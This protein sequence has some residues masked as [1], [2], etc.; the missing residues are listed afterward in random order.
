MG[1][2]KD[3][4]PQLPY[5]KQKLHSVS[6]VMQPQSMLIPS[7]VMVEELIAEIPAG[8]TGSLTSIRT[9]LA[10]AWGADATCPVTVR[11]HVQEIAETS[12]AAY[13]GGAPANGIT[14]FWRVVDPD[15][16]DA[17]RLPGGREFVSARRA[18]ER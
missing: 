6:G 11:R 4:G 14:P 1:E 3:E 9:R 17:R 5:I 10:K 13:E 16:P 12:F 7:R 8:G 2:G 15:K 18:E